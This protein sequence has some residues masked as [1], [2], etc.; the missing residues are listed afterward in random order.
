MKSVQNL[1]YEYSEKK[2]FNNNNL[3]LNLFRLM[4][5][6]CE[7]FK[8]VYIDVNDCE[9]L[10]LIDSIDAMENRIKELK[11]RPLQD[12]SQIRRFNEFVKELTDVYRTTMVIAQS[13][14]LDLPYEAAIQIGKDSKTREEKHGGEW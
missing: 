4:E 14:E 9:V 3:G 1:C 10:R 11:T 2:G 5:E 6:V 8:E 13:R 12:T 7:L